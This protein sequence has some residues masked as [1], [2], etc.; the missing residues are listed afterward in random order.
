MVKGEAVRRQLELLQRGPFGR[1]ERGKSGAKREERNREKE[2]YNC[3][4][5]EARTVCG[6]V[7][8]IREKLTHTNVR[9]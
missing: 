3:T 2:V 7:C 4:C 6:C 9:S 1:D 8:G 5:T